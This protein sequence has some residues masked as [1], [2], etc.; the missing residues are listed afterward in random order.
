VNIFQMKTQP[1]GIERINEFISECFVCIGYPR[2]GNLAG[3]DRDGI[4]ELLHN[5]YKLSGSKLGN[6]LGIV[7]AFVN[8]MK[9]KDIV[10]I[11]EGDWI[12]IG[13]VGDYYFDQ[14]LEEEGL[15]HRRDVIW[16]KKVQKHELNEFVKELLRNRSIITKFKHPVDIAELNT[17]INPKDN[18]IAID[19]TTFDDLI[20]TDESTKKAISILLSAMDS[21]NEGI[22]VKAAVNVLK[23]A[24]ILN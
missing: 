19:K 1:L 10:L 21:E 17:L 18:L 7:N 11:T 20:I 4:R 16:L 9:S 12:H 5:R 13:E 22:R 23:L 24:K 14:I 15:S 6:H 8:T 3:V 2:L